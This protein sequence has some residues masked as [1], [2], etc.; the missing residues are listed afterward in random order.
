[1]RAGGSSVPRNIL[2]RIT[3]SSPC[4]PHPALARLQA[5]LLGVV[6]WRLIKETRKSEFLTTREQFLYSGYSATGQNLQV[7]EVSQ[8]SKVITDR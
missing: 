3:V 2:L 5:A 1:M 4:L 8:V 6:G 7:S